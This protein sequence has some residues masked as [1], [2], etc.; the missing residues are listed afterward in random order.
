MYSTD[1]KDWFKHFDFILLDIV[2]LQGALMLAYLLRHGNGYL[3]RSPLYRNV[4]IFMVL[5]NFVVIFF[6]ESFKNVLKR[7]VYAELRASARHAVLVGFFTLLYLFS[8][9]A[10]LQYSRAVL[11]VSVMLYGIFTWA[12]RILWKKVL[13][14]KLLQGERRSLLLLC[15]A[16]AAPLVVADIQRNQRDKYQISGL[17]LTDK[18][19]QGSC[20]AGIPVVGKAEE[21]AEYICREW[22]DEVF[23]HTFGGLAYPQDLLEQLLETGVAIHLNLEKLSD[24]AGK[25]QIVERIG[26]YTVLT[27]GM[28][29]ITLRQAFMK[30]LM[31]IA[32][33][34]IGCMMTGIIFLFV[35]PLIY[36]QSPGPIFF[37]QTRVG[38]NGKQFKMY[39]FRTMHPDAEI[40]KKDLE[41]QNRVKDGLMFKLDFDPRVIG[42]RISAD[43]RRRTGIG[44]FLRA[45]SLDEFP[46][47]FNVLKGDMSIVGTRPPTVDEFLRYRHHHCARLAA[48]PGI[49]GMWQVSGRSEITDFEEIVKMDTRYISEWNLGLDVKILFKT[50]AVV[51]RRQG[52]M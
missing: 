30:R 9:Q 44:H 46:Q 18:D 23:I 27:T 41:E 52:A 20:I 37:A 34:C 14:A 42:N 4:S 50:L 1:F 33:G 22:V 7:D 11:Y 40:R 31:D 6:F 13:R 35:A 8:L 25:K 36:L 17:L 43:G 16:K 3:Y 47:F 15:E 24:V 32:G 10:G 2:C 49:T 5:L 38:K 45:S 26:S 12:L 51:L 39:K 29:C 28:K 21:A 48:K 19:A